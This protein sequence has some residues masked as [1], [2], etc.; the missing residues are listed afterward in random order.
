LDRLA[1]N[2]ED[3][4]SRLNAA[5]HWRWRHIWRAPNIAKA[6]SAWQISFGLPLIVTMGALP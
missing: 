4:W 1:L 5:N 3:N 6:A 2:I